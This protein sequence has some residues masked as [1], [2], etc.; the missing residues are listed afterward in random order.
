MQDFR[1]FVERTNVSNFTKLLKTE[2]D[3]T[4]RTLLLTLLADEESK[5]A[6][7]LNRINRPP[8]SAVF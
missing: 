3:P 6:S 5:Q 1:D 7:H 4:K 8:P 2:P